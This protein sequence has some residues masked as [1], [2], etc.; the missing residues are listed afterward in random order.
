MS[1]KSIKVKYIAPL[2]GARGQSVNGLPYLGLENIESGTGKVIETET[3][4]VSEGVTNYYQKDDVLF[5]KLRPY[6]AKVVLAKNE[7]V[8]TGELLVLSPKENQVDPRFLSYRLRA[9]DFIKMVDNSTYGAKMPR[10][11]WNFIGNVSI[12]LPQLSEQ[13][14]IA[15]TLDEKIALLDQA[16]EREKKQIEL[17]TEYRQSLIAELVDTLE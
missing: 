5:G 15:D 8:C 9:D 16:I 13:K 2:R 10:A 1:T 3:P 6:L 11:N 17:L 14:M 7:G 4:I 12:S